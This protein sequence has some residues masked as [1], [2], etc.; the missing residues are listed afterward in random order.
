MKLVDSSGLKIVKTWFENNVEKLVI[1]ESGEHRTMI[2]YIFGQ[3]GSENCEGNL[4]RDNEATSLS[5]NGY[6]A[7]ENRLFAK[8]EG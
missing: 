7:K 8:G 5:S 6:S 1:C 4:R 3:K 2:N